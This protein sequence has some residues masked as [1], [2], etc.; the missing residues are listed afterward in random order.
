MFNF[1]LIESEL[2]EKLKTRIRIRESPKKQR[3][4]SRFGSAE[5]FRRYK[6]RKRKG[7][8]RKEP[9]NLQQ[10]NPFTDK[11]FP[12]IVESRHKGYK[13]PRVDF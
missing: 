13:R 7:F 8:T 10:A 1:A 11:N 12:P 5:Y 6:R 2:I 4:K 3:K 9:P